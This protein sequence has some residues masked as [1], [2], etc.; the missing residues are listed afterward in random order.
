MIW[1][2][3]MS[4]C[5]LQFSAMRNT[6]AYAVY[7]LATLIRNPKEPP[8]KDSGL[9]FFQVP[10]QFG[11]G[12]GSGFK[13]LHPGLVQRI[14]LHSNLST[15]AAKQTCKY[16]LAQ[17]PVRRKLDSENCLS[18]IIQLRFG[19]AL[20]SSGW[21]TFLLMLS[22]GTRLCWHLCSK[23]QTSMAVGL[24]GLSFRMVVQ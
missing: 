12:Y 16:R 10:W 24:V 4:S 17:F 11:G 7:P 19:S 9:L 3:S 6:R 18:P 2:R 22:R 5:S 8:S 14:R 23:P 21:F 1:S 20:S 15:T 13:L